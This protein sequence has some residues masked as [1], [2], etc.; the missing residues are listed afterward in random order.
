MTRVI[1]LGAGASF[2]SGPNMPPLGDKLFAAL[3]A[4]GGQ[5]ATLPDALKSKFRER[6]EVGMAAFDEHVNGN[7]MRFQRELAHFLAEYSPGPENVYSRLIRAVGPQRVIFSSLNYD[8]LFELSAGAL[9]LDTVYSS[10]KS[11]AN[12]RLLKLHGSSNFW[13]DIGSNQFTNCIFEG[14]GIDIEAPVKPLNQYDTIQN[15]LKQ[16]SLAPA[17]AMHAEGKEKKVCPSYVNDQQKQW[18]EA[19]LEAKKVAVIGTRIYP[20]DEHVWGTL[21]T[22][23]ADV[24]YYGVSELDREEF[25]KWKVNVGRKNIYFIKANF[26]EA[27][28]LVAKVMKP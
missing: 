5:A 12:I 22:T 20:L 19:V 13:P 11:H 26:A 28:D 2:G 9:R 18:T 4:R 24:Y 14:N 16:D 23:Q 3:E 8:L 15:C 6:F 1:L 10:K 7:V 25:D 21:S 17:I 27:V